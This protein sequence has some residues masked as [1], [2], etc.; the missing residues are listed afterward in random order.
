MMLLTWSCLLKN[1]RSGDM[2]V[3]K[4]P[5]ATIETLAQAMLEHIMLKMKLKSLG[6]V[7]GRS[8]MKH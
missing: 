4:S 1:G 7:M 8:Y 6:L 3:Q 2:F 5:A